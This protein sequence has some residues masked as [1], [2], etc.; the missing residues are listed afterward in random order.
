[1]QVCSQLPTL[2]AQ[3]LHLCFQLLVRLWLPLELYS[4]RLSSSLLCS[5]IEVLVEFV[6]RIRSP[7]DFLLVILEV[8][9]L[10]PLLLFGI[11]ATLE[12]RRELVLLLLKELLLPLELRIVLVLAVAHHFVDFSPHPVDF[13][14]EF[15]LFFT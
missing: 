11:S 15:V 14:H 6:I 10:T 3:Q 8:T 7:L 12:G 9:V 2:G 5:P 4:T 1:M 13:G